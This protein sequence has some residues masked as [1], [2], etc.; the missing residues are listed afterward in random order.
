MNDKIS[1]LPLTKLR[2]I[3]ERISSAIAD[4]QAELKQIESEILRR[5]RGSLEKVLQERHQ[6]HGEAI[7]EVDDVK[8]KLGITK[9]VSW[10]SDKLKEIAADLESELQATLFNV[11][12]TIPER[13]WDEVSSTPAGKLLAAARTVKYSEPKVSFK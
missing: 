11:K 5:Y 13:T 2:D 6:Q 1:N 10:D 9:T 3:A 7:I 8:L 12:I 4:C